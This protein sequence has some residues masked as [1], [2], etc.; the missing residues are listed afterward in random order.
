MKEAVIGLLM[1]GIMGCGGSEI[2][3]TCS[4]GRVQIANSWGGL[5]TS[6]LRIIQHLN[7]VCMEAL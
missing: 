3:V 6:E 7:E 4:D 2:S 5:G 1:L